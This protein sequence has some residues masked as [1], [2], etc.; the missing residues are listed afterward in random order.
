MNSHELY[1]A[2]ENTKFGQ[3]DRQPRDSV[4]TLFLSAP[5]EYRILRQRTHYI[6]WNKGDSPLNVRTWKVSVFQN[7]PFV[8]GF[9]RVVS[10][11]SPRECKTSWIKH[12]SVSTLL[13]LPSSLSFSL[14]F[15]VLHPSMF[16]VGRNHRNLQMESRVP[17]Y[18]FKQT[19]RHCV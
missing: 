16:N 19:R 11:L 12:C 18:T 17:S 13:P 4:P 1:G 8:P 14:S 6:T 3:A 2:W 5:L 7:A 9:R 15:S 10:A